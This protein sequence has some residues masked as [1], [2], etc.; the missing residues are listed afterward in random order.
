MRRYTDPALAGVA[1]GTVLLVSFVVAG[2]GIGASGA[3][4]STAGALLERAT[5][6]LQLGD[7]LTPPPSLLGDWIVLEV[8][9]VVAGGFAS[10]LL[11]GRL[12]RR[13]G[14]ATP[15]RWLRPLLGGV[16]MGV[17]ARL[18]WG[19]TSGLAL[20]GGALLVTG[21]WVFIPLAFGTAILLANL[22]RWFPR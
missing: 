22:T 18:A 16:L 21:A 2:R 15:G 1:L 13:H 9:G 11:A 4:A 19:C 14:A 8:L 12:V 5:P 17:G 7:R 20:S 10:A 6:A 3:F